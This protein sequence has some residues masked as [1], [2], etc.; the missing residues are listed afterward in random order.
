MKT[1]LLDGHITCLH[2][3]LDIP[4]NM[5]ACKPNYIATICSSECVV[6]KIVGTIKKSK[7]KLVLCP[8]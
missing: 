4:S 1:N 3:S 8:K 2:L 5:P 7:V 6:K